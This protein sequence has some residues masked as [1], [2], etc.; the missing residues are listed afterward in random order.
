MLTDYDDYDDFGDDGEFS[1]GPDWRV[2]AGAL[3]ALALVASAALWFGVLAT[4]GGG[5]GDQVALASTGSQP[6]VTSGSTAPTATDADP[7]D[8]RPPIDRSA[9]AEAAET[10]PVETSTTA[11]REPRPTS[12]TTDPVAT[13]STA[14]ASYETLPDG[15]PVPV[16]A[17]FDG[18][19]VTLSGAVP[20]EAAA[21][22]LRVLA[23]AN[24]T[25]PS[26]DVASFL[27]VDPSV[28]V[29]VGVRVIEMNSAR[30]PEGSPAIS[31]EHAAQ[32]N[33]VVAIMTALPNI[34][35]KVI[36]H[37]DQRGDD[38]ANFELSTERARAAADYLASQGVDPFRLSSRGAGES[39]L[40]TLN[41]DE[42]ALALNRR[43]E[44]VFSG[45]LVD[46]PEP[47]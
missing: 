9:V 20:S 44:F 5:E 29:G 7:D 43:T 30:F 23:L 11:V 8:G 33:R 21:E 35:V 3:G 47:T 12:V 32:L 16:L 34:T 37:A 40:L 2:R 22:R 24:S 10:A 6:V 1:D 25:V 38:T 41:N 36:G 19:L 14:P 39:D 15:S 46:A 27:T 28:P 13:P 45:L 42:A 4:S 17:I 31:V 26:A 18:Q